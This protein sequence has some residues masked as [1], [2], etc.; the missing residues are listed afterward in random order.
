MPKQTGLYFQIDFM[1][2]KRTDNTS[3][4]AVSNSTRMESLV[5][6][7]NCKSGINGSILQPHLCLSYMIVKQIHLVKNTS[8]YCW[9]NVPG[10]QKFGKYGGNNSDN[11]S[12]VELGF[13]P[14]CS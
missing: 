3:D 6:E 11:G 2:V 8:D 1:I 4:W 12:Y 5:L 9:H 13:K 10:L 14:A 7:F